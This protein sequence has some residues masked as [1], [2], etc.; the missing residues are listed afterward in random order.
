[1]SIRRCANIRFDLGAE[2]FV[3][4]VKRSLLSDRRYKKRQAETASV[5]MNFYLNSASV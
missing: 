1:M 3:E 5:H 4:A 2:A